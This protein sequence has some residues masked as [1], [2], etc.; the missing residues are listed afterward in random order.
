M[1]V[2]LPTP[3]DHLSKFKM[4]SLALFPDVDCTEKLMCEM[5]TYISSR[6]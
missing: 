3:V 1:R 5:L 2:C 6:P 4:L